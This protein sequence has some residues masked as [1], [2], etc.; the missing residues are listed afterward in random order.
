MYIRLVWSVRTEK[1]PQ[2]EMQGGVE[3]GK[4]Y[5]AQKADDP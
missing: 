3:T 4:R 5:Q 1:F 2:R